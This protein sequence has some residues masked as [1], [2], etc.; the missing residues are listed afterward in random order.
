MNVTRFDRTGKGRTDGGVAQF[1]FGKLFAG[2]AR[3]QQRLQA[4]HFLERYVVAGLR[5]LITAG[6]L[7]EL[8]L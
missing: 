1:L 3:N 2:L 8:L 6:G 7:I 5:A 4:V